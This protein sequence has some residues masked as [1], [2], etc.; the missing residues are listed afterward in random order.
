[1][2]PNNKPAPLSRPLARLLVVVLLWTASLCAAVVLERHDDFIVGRWELDADKG[3]SRCSSK[4]VPQVSL[5]LEGAWCHPALS[6]V[7]KAS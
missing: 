7:L 1:M 6:T 4:A 2:P 5:S 3:P